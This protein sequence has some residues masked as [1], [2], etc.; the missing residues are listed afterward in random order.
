MPAKQKTHLDADEVHI[1]RASL[2]QRPDVLAR[3]ARLLSNDERHRASCYV[4]D[5]HRS[6][7]IASRG[8][9]RDILSRYVDV[10]ACDL[11]FIYSRTGKPTLAGAAARSGVT[12]NVSNSGELALYAIARGRAIGV[13]VE[14]L[15]PLGDALTIAD[16]FLS[17]DDMAVI[18]AAPESQRASVFL[19]RWT[20]FEARVKALGLTVGDPLDRKASAP[21]LPGPHEPQDD[22]ALRRAS[23]VALASV[24]LELGPEYVGALVTQAESP[25]LRYIDW[26]V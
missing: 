1:W 2:V 15:R 7:F 3:L 13:D 21:D 20:L 16:R 24:T 19:Q 14:L 8:I 6:Q 25:R 22:T 26:T 11:D 5:A 18:A 12:F 17:A 4:I 10:P 9:Q 23:P